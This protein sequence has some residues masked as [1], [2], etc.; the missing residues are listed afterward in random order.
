MTVGFR[1]PMAHGRARRSAA[2]TAVA[3]N[4]TTVTMKTAQSTTP[5]ENRSARNA[6][7]LTCATALRTA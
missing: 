1:T 5:Q 3:E 6:A 7:T 2:A 4:T